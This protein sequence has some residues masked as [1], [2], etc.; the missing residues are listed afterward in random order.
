M[1][2]QD[3]YYDNKDNFKLAVSSWNGL[4]GKPVHRWNVGSNRGLDWDDFLE[5]YN[6]NEEDYSFVETINFGIEK[7]KKLQESINSTEILIQKYPS[8]GDLYYLKYGLLRSLFHLKADHTF[9][10]FIKNDLSFRKKWVINIGRGLEYNARLNYF[11]NRKVYSNHWE[12][13]QYLLEK[14]I[15]LNSKFSF[16][17]AVSLSNQFLY[18]ENQVKYEFYIDKAESINKVN[19][20]KYPKSLINLSR[21]I[22]L[23]DYKIKTIKSYLHGNIRQI[24]RSWKSRF[25]KETDLN[26][27]LNIF[28]DHLNT[29]KI[30]SN[31]SKSNNIYYPALKFFQDSMCRT[32]CN[33]LK[34]ILIYDKFS[35]ME[36]SLLSLSNIYFL[37]FAPNNV[38]NDYKTDE[39]YFLNVSV[40]Y[41]GFKHLTF[42]DAITIKDDYC[43]VIS[44]TTKL[45]IKHL[46]WYKQFRNDKIYRSNLK[47]SDYINEICK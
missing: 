30:I 32:D 13:T 28:V 19:L 10:Y 25:S 33:D 22:K 40:P 46:S 5:N 3:Y 21:K 6:S 4:S 8:N 41:D 15:D 31:N 12:E 34:D 1:L 44:K 42:D 38:Q 2:K 23:T 47:T 36:S 18:R 24:P 45:R 43:S 20:L 29:I 11:W 9:D 17:A 35:I 27:L 26:E 7:I 16:D 14:V 39:L 37:L